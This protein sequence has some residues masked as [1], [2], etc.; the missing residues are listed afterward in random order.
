MTT[1]STGYLPPELATLLAT[2]TREIDRHVNQ[3]GL[4]ADCGS[5]SPCDR[6][7]LADAA[8]AAL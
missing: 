7:R 5:A 3:A 6:A 1:S 2:A 8:L 4:C